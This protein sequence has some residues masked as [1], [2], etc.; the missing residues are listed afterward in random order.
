M[1]LIETIATRRS[2]HHAVMSWY[3]KN[4]ID[5][6]DYNYTITVQRN[7][8]SVIWNDGGYNE[9]EIHLIRNLKFKPKNIFINYEDKNSKFSFFENDLIYKGPLRLD[10]FDDIEIKHSKRIIVIRDF[11]N[12]L[13]SRITQN[14][15]QDFKMD[16]EQ[17]FIELWKN[18]AKSILNNEIHYIKYEDWLTCDECRSKFLNDVFGIKERV[19][20]E[21][22][23]GTHSSY[24]NKNTVND[25]LNRFDQNIIPEEVKKLIREDN[26]LH[27]LIGAL[28]YT[29]REI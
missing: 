28:G 25:Y 1:N 21:R 9:D 23:N 20:K 27:Y 17:R 13:C 6:C 16:T 7:T 22:A 24:D 14:K 26:E 11:Y 5:V 12:N 4:L 18:H 3:I 8:K 10:R 29:Y 15:K 2:G 19:K